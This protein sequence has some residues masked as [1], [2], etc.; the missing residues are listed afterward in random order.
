MTQ[1]AANISLKLVRE[2]LAA[3][4]KQAWSKLN[5]YPYMDPKAVVPAICFGLEVQPYR[6]VMGGGMMDQRWRMYVLTGQAGSIVAAQMLED[7][8]L[9]FIGDK[10]LYRAFYSPNAAYRASPYNLR[11]VSFV[12]FAR[13]PADIQGPNLIDWMGQPLWGVPIELEV[14]YGVRV[15]DY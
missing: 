7:E 3:T 1:D 10:S 5:V 12:G 13:M 9:D 4:A 2:G 8:L 15:G 11:S 14:Q 6:T